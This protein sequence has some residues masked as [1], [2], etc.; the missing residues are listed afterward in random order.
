MIDL[1]EGSLGLFSDPP[2]LKEIFE[3]FN[4]QY[5]F[6][7]I[8]FAVASRNRKIAKTSTADAEEVE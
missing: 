2:V 8:R 7:A 4:Q 1:I 3:H 6:E 5:S